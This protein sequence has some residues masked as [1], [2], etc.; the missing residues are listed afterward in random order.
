MQLL[1]KLTFMP[2]QRSRKIIQVTEAKRE[3][4][5]LH[6]LEQVNWHSLPRDRY[7]NN[8]NINDFQ[9]DASNLHKNNGDGSYL[10][11]NESLMWPSSLA[12][13]TN[14]RPRV[15]LGTLGARSACSVTI[16]TLPLPVIFNLEASRKSCSA[17]DVLKR[18]ITAVHF[19]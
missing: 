13:A 9:V 19:S 15:P 10:H 3:V 11:Y 18:D 8:L 6:L 7:C 16:Q 2:C 1:T 4:F 14:S 5:P 12:A 17:S